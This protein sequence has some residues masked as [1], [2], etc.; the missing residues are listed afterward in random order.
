VDSQDTSRQP[1]GST[2]PDP[3]MRRTHGLSP[4]PA[5]SSLADLLDRILDK[6]V[7]IAGDI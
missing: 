3:L 2:R 1:T 6:G 5:P 7:I 4:A